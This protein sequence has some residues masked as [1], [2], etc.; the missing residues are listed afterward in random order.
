MEKVIGILKFVASG[1]L[2]IFCIMVY[3]N[4]K[5]VDV[6]TIIGTSIVVCFLG[7]YI[8]Y[9][10]TTGIKNVK[11]QAYRF[12][13]ISIIGLFLHFI[14]MVGLIAFSYKIGDLK[15]TLTSILPAL[16]GIFVGVLDSRKYTALWK[17]KNG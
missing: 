16:F 15:L 17:S 1:C 4:L 3:F 6:Q 9:L 10:I 11:E 8:Y 12:N 2:S 14:F 5:S 13:F 7:I